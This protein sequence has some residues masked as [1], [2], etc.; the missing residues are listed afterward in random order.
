MS[1]VRGFTTRPE[2]ERQNDSLVGKK[3]VSQKSYVHKH[4]DGKYYVVDL[5][6]MILGMIGT[7]LHEAVEAVVLEEN[8]KQGSVKLK[9]GSSVKLNKKDAD[10]LNQM[11]KDLN[12]ANRKSMM[13]VAMTDDAGFE[14]IL[15]FAREAL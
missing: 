1:S 3:K 15:G 13:K 10:L 6:E 11:F 2:A 8:F 9:D 12:S 14:E 4:S 5:K 7:E